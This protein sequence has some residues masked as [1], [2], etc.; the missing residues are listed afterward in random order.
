[1]IEEKILKAR[2]QELCNP[3][4]GDCVSVAVAI[5]E[6]F[7]GRPLVFYNSEAEEEV[8]HATVEIDGRIYDAKGIRDFDY[9]LNTTI[10]DS[11]AKNVIDE[12][13]FEYAD[14]LT[15]FDIYDEKT[16]NQVKREVLNSS[17]ETRSK[18]SC[19]LED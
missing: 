8:M 3:L 2:L 9:L 6:V 11:T 10:V 14:D 15:V 13:M 5:R 1:M 12:D 17:P 4:R 18:L 7:G 16:K 19:R